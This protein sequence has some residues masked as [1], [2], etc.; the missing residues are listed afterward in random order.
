MRPARAMRDNLTSG[1][2]AFYAVGADAPLVAAVPPSPDASS[3]IDRLPMT[4]HLWSMVALVSFGAFFEIYELLLTAPISLGLQQA[5]IFYNGRDGLFGSSDQA[6]FVAA[7]F[8]GLWLGTLAFAT[9]ADRFGRRPIFT[10]A[11]IWYATSTFIMGMQSS[12][13]A[14]DAWRF[15]ASVGIGV[16][17]VAI[18]C[19]LAELMPKSHRGRAFAISTSIQF[20]SAPVVALLAWQLVARD[21]FGVAG[22]RWLAFFPG[23]GALLV[24]WVRRALPESPRWLE[25]HGREPEAD[26][27]LRSIEARLERGAWTSAS[28]ACRD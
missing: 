14:V 2:S 26:L 3:R 16:E 8:L 11:L 5:G 21:L 19:Y 25:A 1:R 22:W 23:V 6:T 10:F 4:R 15:V 17:L 12:A 9:I 18:D 20:L 27:I 24:W 28:I 7:T 13:L